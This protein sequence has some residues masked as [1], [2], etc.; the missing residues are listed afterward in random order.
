M[1]KPFTF[2]AFNFAYA[3][4]HSIWYQ[5]IFCRLKHFLTLLSPQLGLVMNIQIITL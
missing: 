1:M 5:M 4:L 2:L 3:I